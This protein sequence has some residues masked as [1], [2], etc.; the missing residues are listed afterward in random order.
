MVLVSSS[1]L[2]LVGSPGIGR[3][4][5]AFPINDQLGCLVASVFPLL[6]CTIALMI[7]TDLPGIYT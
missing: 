4:G 2:G 5:K 1:E 6:S 3:L 7:N